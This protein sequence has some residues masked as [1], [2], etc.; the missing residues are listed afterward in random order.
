M[1]TPPA[2]TAV[3]VRTEDLARIEVKDGEAWFVPPHGEAYRLAIRDDK[4]DKVLT[5]CGWRRGERVGDG[6]HNV[7]EAT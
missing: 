6:K 3:Y 5:A 4:L 2:V 7:R 1:T